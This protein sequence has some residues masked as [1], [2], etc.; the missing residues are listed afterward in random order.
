MAIYGSFLGQNRGYTEPQRL[1]LQKSAE[2]KRE[3]EERTATL[4]RERLRSAEKQERM[5]SKWSLAERGMM[6]AGATRRRRMMETGLTGRR[7]TIEIGQAE[8]E[9]LADIRAARLSRQ[10]AGRDIRKEEE[11]TLSWARAQAGTPK[12]QEAA[13]QNRLARFATK[14]RSI[15]APYASFTVNPETGET[16]TTTP[17]WAK[18]LTMKYEDL[19]MI[20]PEGAAKKLETEFEISKSYMAKWLTSENRAKVSAY[21]AEMGRGLSEEQRGGIDEQMALLEEDTPEAADAIKSILSEMEMTEAERV[22]EEGKAMA[23]RAPTEGVR[24][25]GA[26]PTPLAESWKG[27]L[28]GRA[29]RGL[30][31]GQ[32]EAVRGRRYISPY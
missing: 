13:I 11:K 26:E 28:L 27:S 23:E 15:S 1:G 7:G 20:D 6:E 12:A 31:R 30:K 2:I 22:R 10:K 5:R 16:I 25:P 32:A 14:A 19:A 4:E 9:R 3:R 29:Y 21:Y 8:R 17:D 18:R 24:R